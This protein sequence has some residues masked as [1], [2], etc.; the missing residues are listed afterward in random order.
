MRESPVSS[1]CASLLPG[2]RWGESAGEG[3]H[4]FPPPRM[5][6]LPGQDQQPQLELDRDPS[7]PPTSIDQGSW[8]GE[9][10]GL[11]VV[12]NPECS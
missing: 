2:G 6:H 7:P 4:I 1:A 12:P 10:G 9:P 3:I 5:L 8:Q 11:L